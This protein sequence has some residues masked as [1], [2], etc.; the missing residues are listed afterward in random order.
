MITPPCVVVNKFFNYSAPFPVSSIV[1]SVIVFLQKRRIPVCPPRFSI[2]KR[3]PTAKNGMAVKTADYSFVHIVKI[4]AALV[5]FGVAVAGLFRK[6]TVL[7]FLF[8]FC[9]L[10]AVYDDHVFYPLI[11]KVYV[12]VSIYAPECIRRIVKRG[13]LKRLAYH[14]KAILYSIPIKINLVALS[15]PIDI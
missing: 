1:N 8:I 11:L 9:K 14:S 5:N 13:K 6:E 2:F 12:P 15:S 7:K 3:R 4:N 10:V